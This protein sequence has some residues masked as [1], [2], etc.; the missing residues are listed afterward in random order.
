MLALCRTLSLHEIRRHPGRS[1]LIASSLALGVVAWT[2]TWALNAALDAA[3]AETT[4][5]AAFAD[6]C[7]S[8]GDVGLGR[9]QVA[10][11]AAVE[12][13]RAAR[14]IVVERIRILGQS[15]VLLGVDPSAYRHAGPAI[16]PTR[17]D[18]LMKG[19]LLGE[20]PVLL[21]ADLR[22]LTAPRGDSLV[23]IIGGR[24]Q[25]LRC[26]GVLD[27]AGPLSTLGGYVVVTGDR[28]VAALAGRPDRVSRIDVELV[29]GS[30]L[31][32]VRDRIARLLGGRGD[33][34]PPDAHDGRLRE[35]LGALRIGFALGGVGALTLALFL[36]WTVFAVNVAER[37][38]T[39]GLL[40]ALGSTR[41]QV[42]AE[43]L[44]EALV[45]G[46][47]GSL[48]GVVLGYGAARLALAPLLRILG[49][50]FVPVYSTG[51]GFDPWVAA[52]GVAAGLAASGLAAWLPASRASSITPS[53]ALKPD[54]ERPK[55]RVRGRA[56][57]AV[58]LL[59]MGALATRLAKSTASP[60]LALALAV[61]AAL[62]LI[63]LVT[64]ALARVLRPLA[65]GLAGMPGRLALDG[66][67]HSPAR[68]GPAVAG[69]AG[70][71]ALLIQTGGV[72]Q[73]NETSVRAW[74]DDC[75]TG[76]LF[77]TSGG[78]L[79]ASGRTTPMDESLAT[80][81]AATLPGTTLVPMRFHH[82]EWSHDRTKSRA[83]LLCLDVPAYLRMCAGRVPPLRDFGLYRRLSRPGTALVSENFAALNHVGIGSVLRLQ[84]GN[85][86]VPVEIV[87]TVA[88]FSDS[89]GTILVDRRGVSRALGDREVDLFA[90]GLGRGA[91]AET[92]RRAVNRSNWAA[93]HAVEAMTRESVRGHIL[94]MIRRLYGV[95][96]LQEVLAAV[97]ASLGVSAA[98]LVGTMQRRRELA[99]L[100]ALGAT[101]R[102]VFLTVIAEAVAMAI[103]GLVLGTALGL[104]IEWCVLRVLLRAETGFVFPV[105]VPWTDGVCV[106]AVIGTAS[107]LAGLAPALAATRIEDRVAFAA[108]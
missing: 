101:R 48:T 17:P 98:M 33:V 107:I 37:Q 63:P 49:D 92:A 54:G 59:A 67:V 7:V 82:I 58:G 50:I 10:R 75:I 79:S 80:H 53:R 32:K 52:G 15:A 31:S 5:P 14:P 81:L 18:A 20:T 103:L 55:L 39:I 3:R 43:I 71:I 35:S 19:L 100:H 62:L 96:Y 34:A 105:L 42:A 24:R 76:D 70:A 23:A 73:G 28:L 45:L 85:G 2:A 104:G 87:G 41:S 11:I 99:L 56:M 26:A 95:A 89:R 8:Q 106:A 30:D 68:T 21:G 16:T 57:G 25:R 66:L 61:I 83:L 44:G 47:A 77:V 38:A 60:G 97:V 4:G 72:I 102:Q 74:V 29:P 86:R 94:G 93:E 91:D 13:V 36:V 12:G 22:R 1:A 6:L 84:S 27:G 40:R 9:E 69:L 108:A 65:E 51:V 78:P 90:V 64:G 88:D 46:A